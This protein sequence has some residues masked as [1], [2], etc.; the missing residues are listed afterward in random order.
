MTVIV[1][2]SHTK[3]KTTISLTKTLKARA[4]T[5]NY[6]AATAAPV[7]GALAGVAAMLFI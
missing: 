5:G 3:V 6:A 2:T 1:K 4:T 7:M